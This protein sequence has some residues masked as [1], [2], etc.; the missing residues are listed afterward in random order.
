[1]SVA[2]TQKSDVKR[3]Q[4]ERG[5]LKRSINSRIEKRLRG[6]FARY[7]VLVDKHTVEAIGL[8]INELREGDVKVLF[9][10]SKEGMKFADKFGVKPP[11]ILEKKKDGSFKVL[12]VKYNPEEDEY[13]LILD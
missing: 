1:M 9:Y 4:L 12:R 3:E 13:T 11:A 6:E 5:R 7:Y 10:E 8:L 2:E